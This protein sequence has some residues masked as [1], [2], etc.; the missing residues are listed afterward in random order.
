MGK[1]KGVSRPF[2]RALASALRA[3]EATSTTQNQQRANTK[4]PASEDKNVAAPNKKKRRAALGD[5]SN[6]TFNA[7]KPEAK[8]N[9][10][11]VKKEQ[12]LGK[13]T[14]DTAD[15]CSLRLPPRPL[16]RSASIVEKSVVIGTS[17]AP[18]IPK[19]I[20]IDLDDKDPLLCCLYAP[21]IYYNLRVSELRRRPVA[22]FMERIQK[23]VTESMRGILVD[24]LVEVAEEY[25]L[26]PETLYLTV[27]LIDWFLHGNYMD[28]QRLQLLGIT[29]MLIASKYEE[30]Y[31]PRVEEF[32]SITDNTYTRDQVL[33][34]EKQVL[35]HFSFQVYTPTPKSFLRRFLRAAQ[36]SYLVIHFA[37]CLPHKKDMKIYRY[38]DCCL[39]QS[40]H[41]ELEFL[42]S[43]L[44]ELTL[45]D[46]HFLKFLPSV[47]AASAVFLA[48]WTLDQS[49]HPWN[50][51]LEHYTTYK[52]SELK[53]AVHALQ[54]LQRN[55]KGCPLS[56]IRT[57]YKQEIFK[58]VAVLTSPKLLDT[59]F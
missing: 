4:R 29:C 37:I 43:Y 12:G 54:D 34:M 48:K 52:A 58:S 24:W 38:F 17:T 14:N 22:D 3:S 21:D 23:D 5:I 47:I 40:M 9:T 30:I 44:T 25:T 28:R 55:T 11:Q 45:I 19:F 31:A 56:A 32:C 15:N 57:K 2:T 8:N 20:D 50:P 6:V 51:T 1:E 18:D 41:L 16:G 46:Y 53:A 35:A 26:V 7:A 42:A 13:G 10:K 49:N 33:E 36:G 27:H 39:L 59:L